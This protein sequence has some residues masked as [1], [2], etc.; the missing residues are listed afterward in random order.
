MNAVA[1]R[2]TLFQNKKRNFTA[3][4]YPDKSLNGL[5]PSNIQS[6]YF[7]RIVYM[8]KILSVITGIAT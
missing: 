1:S 6:S 7:F 4:A 5:I 8:H 2:P 3:F